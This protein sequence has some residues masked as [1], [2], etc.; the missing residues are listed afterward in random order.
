VRYVGAAALLGLPWGAGV[1][2]RELANR[3]RWLLRP[4]FHARVARRLLAATGL[5]RR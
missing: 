3:Y 5:A 2:L 1:Y 4:S